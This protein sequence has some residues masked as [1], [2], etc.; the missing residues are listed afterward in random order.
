MKFK[1]AVISDSLAGLKTGYRIK[2]GLKGYVDSARPCFFLGMYRQEDFD[3]YQRHAGERYIVFT[4]SD[5]L[6]L[7]EQWIKEIRKADRIIAKSEFVQNTLKKK[8][9]RSEVIG[10]SATV[11][12]HWKPCQNGDKLFW[13]YGLGAEDFY[14]AKLIEMIERK[15]SIPII[16]ANYKT[17]NREQLHQAYSECFLNLRL[18]PHDG[19]PNTNLQ[20]GLMG[21]KSIYNG[22]LPY[23]IK[24][25]NV[26][27][28]IE[29]IQ[30]EY[31]NRLNDNIQ[32]SND[33]Y[34]FVQN[35]RI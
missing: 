28:I 7:P 17:F 33:F 6:D 23:S 12:S 29:T 19:C 10:L 5:A 8:R 30:N 24:W 2:Y 25:R 15:I 3:I 32:V 11:A 31:A 13:Y 18:T 21:R 20:M 4:G 27:D 9:I 16:K 14:G 35:N 34:I 22:S 1:Q 26:K